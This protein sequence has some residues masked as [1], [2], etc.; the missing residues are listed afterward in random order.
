MAK[1]TVPTSSV[2]RYQ[3]EIDSFLGIDLSNAINNVSINRSPNCPNMI[4][5]VVGK[6]KKRDGVTTV[7][8]FSASGDG[9]INGVHFLKGSTTKKLIHTGTNIYLDGTTPTLLYS[10]ANNHVS[11]SQQLNNKLYILDGLKYLVYD[12]TTVES[13]QNNSDTYIPT[14]IIARSPTGGGSTLENI[15][16]I[17]KW[18]TEK[19]TGAVDHPESIREYYVTATDLDADALSSSVVKYLSQNGYWY[20]LTYTTEYTIPVGNY[21]IDASSGKF[22]INFGY[23]TVLAST[24][25]NVS[26]TYAKTVSGYAD[27]IDKCD[28]STL[29]GINAARDRI[30]TSGN[31]DF[32]NYDWYSNFNDPTYFGDLN[33]CV[34]GQNSSAILGYSIVNEYLVT[35]KNE[36][37]ND[38]NTNLRKGS[39]V[40]NKAV[41]A[42]TGSYQAAGALAKHAFANLE[43]EPLYVTTDKNISA[44]TPSDVLGER[45][46]QERSYFI[47]KAL[48]NES[49]L[50][51]AF[52][53]VFDNFYYL[54]VDKN[55]YILDG[56]QYSVQ[57]NRP[58][59][60]RQFEC[61]LFPSVSDSNITCMWSDSDILYFGTASGKIRKFDGT[62]DDGTAITN[63]WDTP[64]LDGKSFADK[65]TFT[66]VGTRL[67]SAVKTGI[68]ISA[69]IKGLWQVVKDYNSEAQYIDFNDID[70]ENFTFSTDTTPHTLGGK[71]KIKNVDKIQFRLENSRLD[72]PFELYKAV[73]EYTEGNKYRK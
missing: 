47:T 18:R 17:N 8:T 9:K 11:V 57:K 38:T 35:H 69:K 45:F 7:K 3:Y 65:K 32:P 50:V 70:F 21:R 28:I 12:G 54:A 68:R 53:Y 4:R 73:F 61:Y 40:D 66:Y 71:I 48:E 30:F 55:I 22:M 37:E 33:Y 5:D 56:L 67:A 39:L 10:T 72:E 6:V 23:D 25:D 52:G 26:I 62:S 36:S 60:S 29:Y 46:S 51:N 31:S 44:I 27:K 43:N 41:F 14:I 20:T 42:S 24:E 13:V 34:I 49:N 1:F 63:Y 16:L 15:N 2:K 59:S 58:Y 19:F 64:E